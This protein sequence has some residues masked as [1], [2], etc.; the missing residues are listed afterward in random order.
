MIKYL[1]ERSTDTQVKIETSNNIIKISFEGSK[2]LRDIVTATGLTNIKHN[3]MSYSKRLNHA[4]WSVY[5]QIIKEIN[6]AEVRSIK[7]SGHSLG[8]G[9]A[10]MLTYRLLWDGYTNIS[11][12]LTGSIRAGNKA[13]ADFLDHGCDSITWQE[14]GNDPV[15]LI[16]P[17]RSRVG[18]IDT[19]KKRSFPWLD[20]NLVSGDHMGYWNE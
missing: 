20:L 13:F 17:W 5:F 7:L 4:I 19:V 1:D 14:C 12:L 9:L 8:G 3:G 10:Q 15:P 6:R 11:L 18:K 16:W 2:T